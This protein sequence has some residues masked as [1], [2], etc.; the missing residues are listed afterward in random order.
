MSAPGWYGKLPALGDFASRRLPQDF[1]RPWDGWLQQAIAASRATLGNAWLDT[2]LTSCIW[3]FVLAADC[4]T[5]T[6]WAGILLP[7]VDR[8]GRYFP[9]TLAAPFAA[10]GAPTDWFAALEAA[11]HAGLA[12]NAIEAFEAALQTIA[13]PAASV[14]PLAMTP[15]ESGPLPAPSGSQAANDLLMG[16]LAGHSLWLAADRHGGQTGCVC[17]GLPGADVFT[18]MLAYTPA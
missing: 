14:G 11:A 9:L 18:H 15:L 5:P 12:A 10:H 3:R 7:S 6:P 13:P 16:L 17:H 4:L 2:Y 8:V 1:I